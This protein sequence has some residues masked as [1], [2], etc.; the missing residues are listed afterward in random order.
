MLQIL[1]DGIDPA[2]A[3]TRGPRKISTQTYLMVSMG[4]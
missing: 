1:D 4:V 2:E 3:L